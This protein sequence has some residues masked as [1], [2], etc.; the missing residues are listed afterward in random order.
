MTVDETAGRF[1]LSASVD[2]LKILDGAI[3]L[4]GSGRKRAP[5]VDMVLARS[6]QSK[7]TIDL[8]CALKFLFISRLYGALPIPLRH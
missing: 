3:A 6:S 8:D 2:P 7:S 5:K 4:T 1:Q